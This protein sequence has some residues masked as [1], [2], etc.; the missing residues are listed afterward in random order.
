MSLKGLVC[1]L[2]IAAAAALLLSAGGPGSSHPAHAMVSPPKGVFPALL[3]RNVGSVVSPIRVH[4]FYWDTAWDADNPGLSMASIDAATTAMLAGTYT[5]SLAQYGITGPHAFT[6]SHQATA[7]CG[8]TPGATV[9]Y[10]DISGFVLCMKHAF[11]LGG[12]DATNIYMV[13][14]P[15]STGFSML[16]ITSCNAATGAA[17]F[18]GFHFQTLPSIVPPDLPQIFGITFTQCSSNLDGTTVTGSHE[19]VE[20]ATDPLPPFDWIDNNALTSIS[21][22][23]VMSLFTTGEAADI[24]STAPGAPIGMPTAAFPRI[25]SGI[26]TP[27]SF[28]VAYYWSNAAG[29]CVPLPHTITLAQ[30]GLPFASTATFDGI[31]RPLPFS[32][33]VADGTF[34]SFSFPSP[35]PDLVNPAGI[36]YVTTAAAFAGTVT[37]NI[38]R[39]A[40]YTTQFRTNFVQFGIPSA[41]PWS[42]TVNGVTHSGPFNDWFDSGSAV[43]FAYQDPVPGSTPGRRFVLIGTSVASPFTASAPTTVVGTYKLQLFVLFDQVGIPGG[44]PWMVTVNGTSHAGPFSDWFDDG[45]TFVFAYQDP[46]PDLAPGTRYHLTGTNVPSPVMITIPFTVLATY[47]TQ[48][49]LRVGTSGLGATFT[50]VFNGLTLLGLANDT[51]PVAVW[52]VHGTALNLSVDN[53]VSGPGGTQFVFQG[54]LPAPPAVLNAPFSTIAE[55]ATLAQMIADALAGGGIHGPGAHGIANSLTHKIQNAQRDIARDHLRAALGELRAFVHEVEAQS[56]NKITP[57]TARTLELAALN[58]F[59]EILCRALAEG[60]IMPAQAARDYAWYASQVT[61][62]GGTPLPPC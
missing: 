29:A 49:L 60:Q 41:V 5:S 18:G 14:V 54:F 20:A 21:F 16:G 24:C 13:Y 11:G 56:G 19:M 48:H 7:G 44:V 38:S 46:V 3:D 12:A 61:R 22:P 36:R 4:N 55:Y 51:T 45:T 40:V 26:P 39:T 34:H 1:K 6:L 23:G 59:H 31:G 33:L 62:L 42:V 37:G 25:P 47:E 27:T 57:G 17:G 2:G 50:H 52:L 35:V 32:T 8:G 58:I 43:S 53:P 10:F 15:R 30:T 9:N 28:A